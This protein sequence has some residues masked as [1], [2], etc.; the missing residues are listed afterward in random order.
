MSV[1]D[2]RARLGVLDPASDDPAYWRR[3]H[4]A[5]MERSQG[6]LAARRKQSVTVEGLVLSWGRVVLPAALAA[7]AAAAVLLPG[8]PPPDAEVAGVEEVLEMPTTGEDPLPAFLHSDRTFDRDL[9][10]LAVELR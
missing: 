9:V 8:A 10:L 6:V 1:A 7:V 4:D 2:E 3:F 5:V